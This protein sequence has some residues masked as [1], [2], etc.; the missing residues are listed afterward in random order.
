MTASPVASSTYRGADVD[1][2][3]RLAQEFQQAAQVCDEVKM[4]CEVIVAAA[5]IFGPFGA[6]FVSYLKTVVIPWLTK[7]SEALKLMAK[8]LSAHSHAQRDAS[9]SATS[10][11]SY[12]TPGNLPTGNTANYPVLPPAATG[13]SGSGSSGGAGAAAP[14][15][16]GG[17][18]GSGAGGTTV[19]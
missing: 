6:A 3:D 15:P 2:L 4:A 1:G 9:S 11:P 14:A 8:V 7:I 16:V 10:L 19:S 13:S 12:T 18:A 5:F 17:G